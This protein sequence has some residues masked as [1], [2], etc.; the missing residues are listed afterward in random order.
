[1]LELKK[2]KKERKK[3]DN[4]REGWEDGTPPPHRDFKERSV[5]LAVA[6]PNPCRAS[7]LCE[8]LGKKERKQT[9]QTRDGGEGQGPH[10]HEQDFGRTI[11]G[12]GGALLLLTRDTTGSQRGARWTPTSTGG[13]ISV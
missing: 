3:T 10:L 9:N 8:R 1:M 13:L 11:R 4:P 2:R 7:V 6:H 12:T 5:V